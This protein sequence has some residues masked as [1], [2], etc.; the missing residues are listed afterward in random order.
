MRRHIHNARDLLLPVIDFFY[1]PFKRL[2]PLQTFRYAVS[3]GANALLGYIVFYVSF[4]YVFAE[5]IFNLGFY[6]LKGHV[7][8]LL[9][10]FVVTFPVGFFMAKYVVFSDSKMKWYVQMFRYFMVCTFN[11]ALNYLLLK[12]LV[13]KVQIYPTIAQVITLAV[14]ILISYLAQRNFSFKAATQEEITD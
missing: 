8:A 2:M 13:E 7:A 4:K 11:L 14:V 9:A 12:I 5:R 1:P 10:S 6:A 3:G